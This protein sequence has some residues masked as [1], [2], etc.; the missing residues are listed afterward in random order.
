MDSESTYTWRKWNVGSVCDEEGC[1]AGIQKGGR[2]T[3]QA[4]YTRHYPTV[5][6]LRSSGKGPDL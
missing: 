4:L 3:E 5:A 2:C 1:G 6:S